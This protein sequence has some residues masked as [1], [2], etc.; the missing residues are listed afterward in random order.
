MHSRC[1]VA[2]FPNSFLIIPNIQLTFFEQ[3]LLNTALIFYHTLMILFLSSN[4]QLRACYYRRLGSGLFFCAHCLIFICTKFYHLLNHPVNQQFKVFLQIS[5]HFITPNN[6]VPLANFVMSLYTSFADH[7]RT[8]S[9]SQAQAL[10]LL[11]VCWFSL[12]RD[13][14]LILQQ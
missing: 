14:V 6:L 1:T 8:H 2:G 10:I 13:L 9:M 12:S 7:I 5:P 3:I 4:S 11:G